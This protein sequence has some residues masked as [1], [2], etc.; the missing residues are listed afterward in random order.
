[1]VA[2][3]IG[4]SLLIP[5]GELHILARVTKLHDLHSPLTILPYAAA[6]IQDTYVHDKLE[7]TGA[8]LL[9]GRVRLYKYYP[10]HWC[11]SLVQGPKDATKSHGMQ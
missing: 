7:N 4:F 10:M 9:L 1:M 6:K 11:G 2:E 5:D 8:Q 3:T